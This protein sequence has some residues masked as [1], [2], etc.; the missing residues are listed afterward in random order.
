MLDDWL[1]RSAALAV[2]AL[3]AGAVSLLGAAPAMAAAGTAVATPNAETLAATV[4]P[5]S[6]IISIPLSQVVLPSPV[7][8]KSGDLF[9]S[10]GRLQPITVTDNRSGDPGW[11]LAGVLSG[12]Q[13]ALSI[14]GED[15]GWVPSV[16]DEAPG[17]VVI[18][19]MT[20]SPTPLSATGA[21]GLA[22]PQILAST[23][24]GSGLGT[25]HLDAALLF[26]A[27]TGLTAG[28][29]TA[30]LTLTAI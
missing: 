13:G 26:N 4:G 28:T 22:Q 2:L 1:L 18:L 30:T 16:V 14:S 5:G 9:T 6:L 3:A 25:A 20:V 27:L 7:L 23:P 11:T 17:Q 21:G 10:A 19:G 8:N 24:A 15:L 29:Y 12:A